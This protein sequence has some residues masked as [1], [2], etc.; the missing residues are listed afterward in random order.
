MHLH[1]IEKLLV[2]RF[3]G[4]PCVVLRLLSL[5]CD[6]LGLKMCKKVAWEEMAWC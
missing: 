4:G 2:A 6:P 3:K 5:L 1:S